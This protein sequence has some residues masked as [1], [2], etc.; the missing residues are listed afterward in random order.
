[1]LEKTHFKIFR[2]CDANE[3]TQEIRIEKILCIIKGILP[4]TS[5]HFPPTKG[6]VVLLMLSS[7]LEF[8]ICGIL[9]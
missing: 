2:F 7:S 4:E 6:S 1:M 8:R 9:I 5:P 3:S